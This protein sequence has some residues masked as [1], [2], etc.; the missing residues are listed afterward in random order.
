MQILELHLIHFGKFHD[1]HIRFSEQM[2]VISGENEYG[3]TTIYAFMKAML[4]GMERGRG[5]AAMKDDFRRYEPWD[6]PNDYAGMMRFRCG[7]RVFRLD[8]RFDRYGKSSSLICENDGEELSIE[9]GDLEMLLGGMTAASFENV[10]A[11]G[12]LTAKPGQGL[13]DELQNYAANYYETGSESIDLSDAFDRLKQKKKQVEIRKRKCQEERNVA[14]A[15]LEEQ[16]RYIR[17]EGERLTQQFKEV[18]QKC[19]EVDQK[20]RRLE[21]EIRRQERM[22]QEEEIKPTGAGKKR[23]DVVVTGLGVFLMLLSIIFRWKMPGFVVSGMLL[24]FGTLSLLSTR[25]KEQG[26]KSISKAVPEEHE[27]EQRRLA[28][29]KKQLEQW[30]WEQTRLRQEGKEKGLQINNLKEQMEELEEETE[31]ERSLRKKLQALELAE[32]KL[33]EAAEAMVST[34]GQRLNQ[35]ASKILREITNGKYDRLFVDEQLRMVVLCDGR[36][37][38]AEQLSRGTLEQIYFALRMAA[39]ECLY[40]EEFPVIFDDAFVCYDEKRLKS[41]LK[42]LSEQSRQVIIFS[43]QTREKQILASM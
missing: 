37:I 43:C 12:Q 7:D 40:E 10:A 15:R 18:E 33:K 13:A 26:K 23:V 29:W 38:P 17:S 9:D 28:E 36:R 31:E 34:S 35:E 3:K 2:E 41:A 19:R 27:E 30:N 11:I 42:W 1:A 39:L 4:F 24:L 16:T 32:E 22:E 8:R 21:N 25:R 6:N 5:R 14:L 20:C